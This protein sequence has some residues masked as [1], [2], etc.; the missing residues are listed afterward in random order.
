MVSEAQKK[1]RN[2]WDAANMQMLGVKV[3]R[4]YAQRLRAVTATHGDTVAGVLRVALDDY[5]AAHGEPWEPASGPDD[6]A[7]GEK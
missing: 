3:R 2:R 1:A 6:G 5:L 7:A 4:D